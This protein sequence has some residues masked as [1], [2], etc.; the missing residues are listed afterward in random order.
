MK[1][2]IAILA[3]SICCTVAMARVANPKP[4]T[5]TQPDGTTIT[6]KL[7]GDERHHWYTDLNGTEMKKDEDGFFRPHI[8]QRQVHKASP[9]T[10]QR[11]P[12][13]R[14]PV[15]D[16]TTGENHFLVL[17]IQFKDVKFKLSDPV[18]KFSAL[19][20]EKG[21]SY[22]GATG[23]VRDYYLENSGNVFKPTF[24]VIGP[25]TA[26]KN[27][28]YYGEN[29]DDGYDVGPDELLYEA[30]CALN[31][32]IDFSIYDT[33]GDGVVDNVFYVFAGYSESDGAD[34]DTIWPHSWALENYEAFFDGVQVFSYACSSELMGTSGTTMDGIGSFCHEFGH[35][36]GLPDFYDTDYEDNGSAYDMF[37]FSLMSSGNYNNDSKTPPYLTALERYLLGWMDMPEEW[38]E[39][40]NKTIQ[41]IQNNV[42]Y[43]TPTSNEDEF[44]VYECRTDQGWDSGLG[45]T[46]L[47]IYH[48]DMSSGTVAGNDI[49]DLWYDNMINAYKSHPCCYVVPSNEAGLDMEELY[50][51][52][53]LFPGY[54][55]LTSFNGKTKPASL[56]WDGKDTGHHLSNIAYSAGLVT[57]TYSK[58]STDPLYLAG[59]NVISNPGN[60]TYSAGS[61]FE[62]KLVES[63]NPPKTVKWLFDG[64]N[65]SGTVTLST[66]KHTVK[67]LLTYSDGT[68]ETIE[69]EISVS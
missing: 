42:A 8:S 30:C 13:A 56:A 69:L 38:T 18:A 34:E 52:D 60:G 9:A 32:S 2:L 12:V 7:H 58:E 46:G 57:L 27:M 48:V 50:E 3:I 65:A 21:Y 10:A 45:D 63:N 5:Y 24:D 20:N 17:L 51:D 26:K 40:G 67:A 66:G 31:S 29:D 22:N 53:F 54:V 68:T 41:G 25:Y 14:K 49:L 36:L 43:M 6:L 16:L 62:L 28:S 39:S 64:E 59:I 4:F 35:V 55:N 1:K 61:E 33:D 23:S 47:L 11:T 44:F 15:K 37:W 19:L